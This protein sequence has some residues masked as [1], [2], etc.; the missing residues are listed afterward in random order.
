MNNSALQRIAHKAGA[1]RVSSE[2]YNRARSI[3]DQ[4][5]DSIV[6]Y[7][8]IYCDHEKKK[9]VTEDHALH[10]IEHVGFSGMYRVSGDTPKCKTSNKKKLIT[11]IKEYQNQSDCV[12]LSKAP[13]EHQI[14]SLGSGYKWS[15][16]S[17]INIQFALEFMLYQL[18]SSALK[19]TINAK[20]V[21]MSESDLDL[22]I[23]L[24]T[25]NCKNIRI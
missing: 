3:G 7:A 10:A 20:R 12:T 23:D 19:V 22:T 15:K 13:I 14:K 6:R 4:Y 18:L 16:E 1:T 9:V 11:R 21:T 8:I 17:L 25:T 24:I 2:V 5:L